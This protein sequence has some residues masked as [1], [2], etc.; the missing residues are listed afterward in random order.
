[1]RK[2]KTTRNSTQL[3]TQ[4]LRISVLPY[5]YYT[6]LP[7]FL[8][9]RELNLNP[10]C[11]Y[12]QRTVLERGENLLFSINPKYGSQ[13]CRSQTNWVAYINTLPECFN[14]DQSPYEQKNKR[15]QHEFALAF[16]LIVYQ[17]TS[18]FQL[19]ISYKGYVFSVQQVN[20]K[21]FPI[22]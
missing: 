3:L 1:M 7:E 16:H 18:Y 10:F 19:Q 5:V 13:K 11:D 22:N 17:R 2:K 12:N 9:L 8:F 21:K 15:C 14:H 6:S 20:S 4:E